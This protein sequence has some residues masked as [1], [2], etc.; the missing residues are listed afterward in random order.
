[1]PFR[2]GKK[3]KKNT[4]ELKKD[5]EQDEHKISLEELYTRLDVDPRVG[6]CEEEVRARQERDGLNVLES[7]RRVSSVY[8]FLKQLVTGFSL[9]LWAGTAL[10]IFAYVA[11]IL[12][13][14]TKN[15]YLYLGIA[16]AGVELISA[17]FSFMQ[18]RKGSKIIESFIKMVPLETVV[19]R[20]GKEFTIDTKE[21]C[22]G[23]IVKVK[24]GDRIPA[25]L[26]MIEVQGLKV[27]NA[28]LTGESTHITLTVEA[29]E[30]NVLDATNI[31]FFSTSA[32]EGKGVGIVINIGNGTV[33]GHIAAL[34]ATI[35]PLETP[36]SREI[37]HFVWFITIISIMQGFILLALALLMGY[38]WLEAII[39]LVGIIVAN[40]PEGLLVTVSVCLTLAAKRMS[41]E[42]CLIKNLEAVETLGSTSV[43]CTDKTG[44]L[45]QNCMSVV[46]L[47]VNLQVVPV[48]TSEYGTPSQILAPPKTLRVLA[49]IAAICTNA[50]FEDASD[51]PIVK[52]QVFGDAS[53]AALIK[54]VELSFGNLEETRASYKKV[55]EIPFTSVSKYHLC[56]YEIHGKRY[57]NFMVVMKGAPEVVLNACHTA[58]VHGHEKPLENSF[59]KAFE[60]THEMLASHGERVLGL[61]DCHLPA[62]HFPR[63][64]QFDSEKM[65]FPMSGF[66]FVGLISLI[67]PPRANVPVAISQ[68]R[69][70]GIRIVMVTGDH[71][72]TAKAI[73]R[74]VGIISARSETIEE[75]GKRLCLPISQV[76]PS[77]A[78]AI[79]L[80]GNDLSKMSSKDLVQVF[81][82]H[83][84]IVFARTSP[85]Q[86]LIV[87]EG[88]QETGAIVAA[89]GDGV[90]DAPALKK[91]DIGVAMG[92]SGTEVSKEAADLILMDDNFA[93]IVRGV[94]E[95]RIIFDNLKKSV[96]Y[97]LTSKV[98]EVGPFIFF[99]IARIP[100]PLGAITILCIDL[101]TDIM[102]AI[103]LAYEE[104][105]SDVM[106]QQPR[107]PCQDRLVNSRLLC[108]AYWQLGV[109]QALA[110][111]FTYFVVMAENGFLPGRL[112]GIQK[113][114]YSWSINDLE[115]SYG[116]EWN[117]HDRKVLEYTCQSAFFVSIVVVQWATLLICKTR[118]NSLIRQGMRNSVLNFSLFFETVLAALLI[119]LPGMDQALHIYPLHAQWWFCAVPFF[120]LAL[121]YGV[122]LTY[123]IR[124]YPGS[125]VEEEMYY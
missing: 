50:T 72:I 15:E 102:P 1:M 78:P 90:N 46:H 23:D 94:E 56:I 49:R 89:T 11:S 115:D 58:L 37:S 93:S 101:G 12:Q 80:H 97:T 42:N 62:K 4:K 52:R 123:L 111:F 2:L 17:G 69:A 113:Q 3:S 22:T 75:V 28:P 103:S 118:R 40:V 19:R 119:Y 32:V 107:D 53:E 21:L 31:A 57:S 83:Q 122:M 65:N 96:M 25:D 109:I 73:A 114:W 29:S 85:Q 5:L 124:H 61:C 24:A 86:K 79:V 82:S 105:E 60:E 77:L 10:C 47:W 106:K 6:L 44:T 38:G 13:R 9:L 16:L 74:K 51:V 87:V 92:I 81:S 100:L 71:P 70:A 48:N 67:D 108:I 64:Y 45:T 41:K 55:F 14:D 98:S 43:I 117:Y 112:F 110:G 91:A 30:E 36:L 35:Q 20:S 34:T 116:Q 121:T 99:V 33:M 88:F 104:A 68:C 84:E 59:M 39:Y 26:R 54:W 76:D 120:F 27:D 18:E 8:I 63:D 125:W 66:R 7:I 95:G